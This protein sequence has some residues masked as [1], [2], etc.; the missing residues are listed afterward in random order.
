[1]DGFAPEVIEM[2]QS[3]TWPGNVRELENEINRAVAFVEEGLKIQTYH[4][5]SKITRGE[6]L[7]QEALSQPANYRELVDGFQ[8]RLIEETLR[9]YGGN[10]SEAARQLGMH[11]SALVRLMKRL[12]ISED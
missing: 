7:I 12:G 2:L 5:S 8:R 3:Y 6:S 11:R 4:F 1:V 10:R 9:E